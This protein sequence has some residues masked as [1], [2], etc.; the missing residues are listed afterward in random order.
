MHEVLGGLEEPVGPPAE[1]RQTPT[2][3]VQVCC[4][5]SMARTGKPF[6]HA[7]FV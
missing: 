7:N 3:A 1:G 2:T 4:F 6:E 5:L